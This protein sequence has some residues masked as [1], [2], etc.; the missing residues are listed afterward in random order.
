M[1]P[2]PNKP[3]VLTVRAA[4]LRSAAR[5]AAHR[6]SFGGFRCAKGIQRARADLSLLP[7]GPR[8]EARAGLC[9]VPRRPEGRRVL[10]CP[11]CQ[12]GPEEKRVLVCASCRGSQMGRRV[13]VCASCRGGQRGGPC[14]SVL[15]AE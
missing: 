5:P 9:L 14:W 4:S 12:E 11:F 15:C 13:L 2:P 8:G 3:M 10:I 1:T 6:Q 7:R